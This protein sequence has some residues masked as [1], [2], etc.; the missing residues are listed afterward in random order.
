MEENSTGRAWR[1][2]PE[3]SWTKTRNAASGLELGSGSKRLGSD[4]EAGCHMTS[5]VKAIKY[6][7]WVANTRANTNAKRNHEF[8]CKRAE[9]T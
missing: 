1:A 7:S 9:G 5:L 8:T 3:G 4:P 2:Q 6:V